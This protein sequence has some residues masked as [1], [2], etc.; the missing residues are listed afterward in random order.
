MDAQATPTYRYWP[1]SASSISYNKTALWLH[2]LERYL[3]WAVLRQ[4][5]ASFYDQ[6]KFGHPSPDD[7]FKTLSE[8]SGQDLSWFFDQVYDTANIFDYGLQELTSRPN[9]GRGFFHD[10]GES[11]FTHDVG[12]SGFETTVIVRRY[13]EGIFPIE[14]VTTFEDGHEEREQWNGE[15]RWTAFTYQHEARATQALVDP[16]RILLLDVNYTN[17]SRT[18]APKADAAAT[19]WSVRWL[20]WLQDL[21]LTYGFFI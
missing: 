3:G 20:I 16:K 7:F 6:W 21:L 1:G 19:K 17:N 18:L 14:I 2:T 4:G 8:E 13:G 12:G 15:T 5:M 9:S 11:R 10:D